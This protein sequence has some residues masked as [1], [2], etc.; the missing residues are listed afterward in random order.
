M[1]GNETRELPII[2]LSDKNLK[3]DT[4][5]WNSTRDSVREAME[6]HGWF[7]AEYNRFPTQLHQSILEAAKELLDLPPEIKIKNENRKAGH[8]YITMNSDGQPVHEG[9][10]IDQVNDIQQC[11]RFS[12]LMWP[13]NDHDNDRFCETIHA[14]AKMQAEL[15]QLVIRMLFESY[16][17]ERYADKHMKG[18]RYLLRLLKYKSLPNGEPNRM[19]MCHTDKSFISILHQNHING[20]MLKSDK[21]D[22][23]YPF[24][25]S[26]T[27]FAV[28]AGD[29]IMAWSNDRIK[30]CYHKV[31]MES[32]ETRYS[33]GFFSFQQGMISTPD[34]MVDKNHPLAYKPFHHDGLLDFYETLE[35][36]LKAHR[37]MTKAYCGIHPISL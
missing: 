35:V 30:G 6:H 5:L 8:G 28:I 37:T 26:P 14:Y 23:W 20:L 34:E 24:T 15:E 7:V 21:E 25:P 12:R 32:V 10:G 2:N 22:V 11:R 17:L 3:Q 31:E 13:N 19:F 16:N 27:R 9:L 33:F 18:S 29:A 1:G 36:H 4:E